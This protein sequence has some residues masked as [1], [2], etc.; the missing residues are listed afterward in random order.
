MS[1]LYKRRRGIS[2]VLTV[3][4]FFQFLVSSLCQ[5]VVFADETANTRLSNY[6]SLAKGATVNSIDTSKITQEELQILG[7]FLSNFYIPMVTELG[8]SNDDSSAKENMVTALVEGASFDKQTAEALVTAIWKMTMES[9]RPLYIGKY[10]G[11]DFTGT[12]TNDFGWDY[13]ANAGDIEIDYSPGGDFREFLDSSDTVGHLKATYFT[14]LDW[15]SGLGMDNCGDSQVSRD[16]AGYSLAL[17]WLDDRGNKIPVFDTDYHNDFGTGA[18]INRGINLT[19]SSLSYLMINDDMNYKH[20][21]GS[22]MVESMDTFNSI[23]S[24]EER[25]RL[26][27]IYAP[28][29]VDCFGNIL[30]DFGT[31]KYVLVPACVNPY[32]WYTKTDEAGNPADIGYNINLVNLFMLD[33]AEDK[34]LKNPI[35]DSGNRLPN[36]YSFSVYDGSQSLLNLSLWRNSR[37]TNAATKLDYDQG[38]DGGGAL[39]KGRKLTEL[40]KKY[41]QEEDGGDNA[42][43]F[44]NW[45]G[46]YSNFGSKSGEY[47]TTTREHYFGEPDQATFAVIP[48]GAIDDLI[49]FDTLGKFK[50]SKADSNG[51]YEVFNLLNNGKG[52]IFQDNGEPLLGGAYSCNF[53]TIVDSNELNIVQN[54]KAKAYIAGI[55][56]SYVLAFYEAKKSDGTSYVNFHYAKNQFPSISNIT[57]DWSNVELSSDTVDQEIKSMIYYFL[58]PVEGI[59][60]VAKWFKNKISGI[61]VSWHEDMVGNSSGT[62]TTGSTKYL[63]FSGYVTIPSLYDIE[64][65]AWLLD[66]Y[67]N[68]VVYLII[69]IFVIMITYCI[70]GSMTFQRAIIGTV[71]FGILAFFP[72]F[73]INAVVNTVNRACDDMYG[74]KFTYWAI[75]QHAT[76][77]ND[78][79]NAISGEDKDSYLTTLF[80]SNSEQLNSSDFTAVRLK[81]IAPKKINV[82]ADTVGKLT[83]LTQSALLSN[84]MAGSMRQ[85]MS[86]EL[87]EDSAEA[88]YLYRSYTDLYLYMKSGYDAGE[89]W[90][91]SGSHALDLNVSNASNPIDASME[92]RL[93]Y[94][95]GKSLHDLYLARTKGKEYCDAFAIDKGFT[96]NTGL[97]DG[98]NKRY[99][100]LLDSSLSKE[101]LKQN[102]NLVE[103]TTVKIN[104]SSISAINS[105][106]FGLSSAIFNTT[107]AKINK[108][109]E[110]FTSGG[111]SGYKWVTDGFVC[112][113]K[114]IGSYYYALYT[115]SPFYYFCWNIYDQ[116]LYSDFTTKINIVGDGLNSKLLNLYTIDEQSYFYNYMPHSADGYGELRDF[117]NMRNLF[118]YVIPYLKACNEGILSWSDLYGTFLYEDVR[119]QYDNG[120][121]QNFPTIEDSDE[122]VYKWWHNYN[123]ERLFNTY[124]PWVDL[125]Y[126]CDYAKSEYITI[127]GEKYLVTDPL[128]PTSYYKTNSM[129]DIIEGRVMVFSRS[130]MKY[131]G[132][133]MSDLTQVEQK[134]IK[135]QDNVY[136][137]L[138]MIADYSGDEFTNDV[139]V[140]AAGMITTFAFNKEFSQITSFGESYTLFPQ[141]YELKAFTYDAYLRLIL[142]ESTGEDLMDT[143]NSTSASGIKSTE[144]KSYYQ[145][146]VENSSILTGICL[147]VLDLFAVYAIPALKLFFLIAIF[148]MSILMIIAAA[149]KL[150]MNMLS[151]VWSALLSPLLKF[152]GVSLGM[153][154]LVSLFMYDGNTA[155]TGRGGLTISLGDPTMVLLVMIIINIVAL[156]LY[157]KICKQCFSK[158]IE[159]A[160][161]IGTSVGGAVIGTLGKLTGTVLRGK[162]TSDSVAR[163]I[164]KARGKSNQP[165]AK[166]PMGSGESSGESSSDSSKDSSS[167]SDVALGA[168]AGALTAK[169]VDNIS[170]SKNAEKKNKYDKKAEKFDKK[171]N[172]EAEKHDTLQNRAK[173]LENYEKSGESNRFGRRSNSLISNAEKSKDKADKL[174]QKSKD[175]MGSTKS[176]ARVKS[177][178]DKKSKLDSQKADLEKFK[179][180]NKGMLSTKSLKKLNK[181][182]AKADKRSQKAGKNLQ[183]KSQKYV[184]DTLNFEKREKRSAKLQSRA[185]KLKAKAESKLIRAEKNKVKSQSLNEKRASRLRNKAD[186]HGEKFYDKMAN[187]ELN[188]LKSEHKKERDADRSAFTKKG[189]GLLDNGKNAFKKGAKKSLKT[190][191]KAVTS[192][193]NYSKKALKNGAK[194]TGKVVKNITHK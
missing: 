166:S 29:Y 177:A 38:L 118:Y 71:L 140:T 72:P 48:F 179:S 9:A 84:I 97:Y 173:D 153:A 46:Y 17:Y 34:H 51:D 187:K 85:Q 3:V 101:I 99:S 175:I 75:V 117:C 52:G 127:L 57:I 142:A 144:K 81:W 137:E 151:T 82:E 66:E 174:S 136:E 105:S 43:H 13:N 32:A 7:V 104:A 180:S 119:V 76:Y 25:E 1:S 113:E 163:G 79:E 183:K 35:N 5:T 37:K 47:R 30:V 24:E 161:A 189:I 112:D 109:T 21:V 12:I 146:I 96:L 74:D 87:F 90:Y 59:T 185:D 10:T 126:S 152:L 132:L 156:L 157:Y 63:G 31:A 121:A 55:Y 182:I 64:W 130:E 20:G 133:K 77:V 8:L 68:I 106:S 141:S 178:Q 159:F 134:I 120:V 40:V 128:D 149:V 69:I 103:G 65:T 135:I 88:L 123:V 62:S 147:I 80:K 192:S 19:P 45:G 92:N 73:C 41:L 23:S 167:K 122:Y 56:V 22:A 16:L 143:S 50:D 6:I 33:E 27:A 36:A 18:V 26:T 95:S 78:L 86:G 108:G 115:E 53:K 193:A 138:L 100:F 165:T 11:Q 188:M 145:R 139:L 129:G 155:V 170:D 42:Q 93:K 191:V 54:G 15:W 44:N 102:K 61:F 67:N 107:M 150:E 4:L 169:A 49:F 168:T 184:K 158:V 154:W 160:K 110:A 194:F 125:M 124:T 186:K 114:S 14:F 131:Y 28:L 162:Q 91:T 116:Q 172:K 60:Y 190:G 98:S 94:S 181:D 164:A 148:F 171:A 83:D 111:T 2:W 39:G 89:T 176:E 70:V 58:H